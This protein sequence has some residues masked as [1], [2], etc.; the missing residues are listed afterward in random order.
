[1]SIEEI[2][3]GNTVLCDWCN[4]DWTERPESGGLLFQSKAT[5]PTCAPSL[6]AD[7]F[8]EHEEHLIRARCPSDVSFA[9][10]VLSVR[11]GNNKLRILSG[12]DALEALRRRAP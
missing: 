6:E 4:E 7:A 9:A 3:F 5:C 1:M 10:W 11:A 12:P 8:R 2:D